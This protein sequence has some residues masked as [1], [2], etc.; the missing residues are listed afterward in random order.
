VGLDAQ[1]VQRSGTTD[2]S[3]SP[4]C[5]VALQSDHQTDVSRLSRARSSRVALLSLWPDLF[6]VEH[7]YPLSGLVKHCL[8]VQD[9]QS[10]LLAASLCLSDRVVG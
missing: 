8:A 1:I 6:L 2:H 5:L 9:D 3:S 10:V 4:V 7:D